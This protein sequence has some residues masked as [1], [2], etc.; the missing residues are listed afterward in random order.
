GQTARP[1]TAREYAPRPWPSFGAILNCLGEASTSRSSL[2]PTDRPELTGAGSALA[3]GALDVAAGCA[4]ISVLLGFAG[5]ADP[6]DPPAQPITTS[7]SEDGTSA[8]TRRR[9]GPLRIACDSRRGFMVAL[10]R[11]PCSRERSSSSRSAVVSPTTSC[12]ASRLS[13]RCGTS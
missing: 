3:A 10:V 6:R 8:R 11:Y 5:S 1:S 2:V 7:V 9:G 13:S 4:D 12:S